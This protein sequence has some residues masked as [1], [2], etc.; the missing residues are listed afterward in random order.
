MAALVVHE[1]GSGTVYEGGV[2]D[3][4]IVDGERSLKPTDVVDGKAVRDYAPGVYD[5]QEVP[6]E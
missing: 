4:V 1:D 2:H 5:V 3:G 6:H